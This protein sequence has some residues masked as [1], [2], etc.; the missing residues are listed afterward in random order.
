[1]VAADTRRPAAIEQLKVLGRQLEIPVHA[2]GTEVP[3]PTILSSW[4][5]PVVFTLTTR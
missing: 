2:E 3:P 4:T 5:Q 1:M